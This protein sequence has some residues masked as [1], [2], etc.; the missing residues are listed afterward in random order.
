MKT[1]LFP[2]Y[3]LCWVF[4][5]CWHTECS[6]LMA[7]LFL[8]L[9]KLAGIFCSIYIR[10]KINKKSWETPERGNA[11]T[12]HLVWCW[13]NFLGPRWTCFSLGCHGNKLKLI[14][15]L[16]L[17]ICSS[18]P[19]TL[20]YPVNQSPKAKLVLGAILITLLLLVLNKID[21]VA[22]PIRIFLFV[23]ILFFILS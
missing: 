21:Y 19:K 4:Q 7:P 11:K 13:N 1:D 6:T 12:K 15:L 10:P 17:W 14:W 5:I 22:Q 16:C 23:S 18:W 3:G 8:G 20:Q 9:W 2:S